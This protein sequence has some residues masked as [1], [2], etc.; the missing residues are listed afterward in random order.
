MPTRSTAYAEPRLVRGLR[1]DPQPRRRSSATLVRPTCI[2]HRGRTCVLVHRHLRRPHQRQRPCLHVHRLRR[3]TAGTSSRMARSRRSCWAR[4]RPTRSRRIRSPTAAAATTRRPTCWRSRPRPSAPAPSLY[5]DYDATPNLNLFVQGLAGQSMIDQPDHGGR[6]AGGVGHRHAHH[7]L[8]GER[9]PAGGRAP[10]HGEREPDLLPDE[11]GRRPRGPGP[12]EPREAGQQHL[13]RHR[14][15]QVGHHPDGLLQRLAGRRL[16]ASTAPPT[17]RATSRASCWIASSAAI[18]AMVDPTNP[19][20][21][22]CRAATI[23]PT[24]WGDCVPLNLFGQGNASD[25][26]IAYVDAL[27]AGPA[28]SPRR[29]SS[30]RTA[31]P[32]ARPSPTPAACG[33]VYN[34]HDQADGGRAVRQRQG[35]GWLGRPHRRGLRRGLPQGRD[36]PDRLRPEQS[37]QRSEHL[38]GAGGSGAAR[39]SPVHRHA[40]FDGPELHRGRTSTATTT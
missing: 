26:A 12:R 24:K 40:Q 17:T 29:C 28:R 5:L 27:H 34:T 7:D 2:L 8:P 13:F 19:G 4:A 31:M 38:S 36:R 18:D 15:L 22:V 23:N 33:K 16:R 14:G 32:A 25:A 30:S 11:R 10:D 1:P 20:N 21:I 37:G 3:C 35:L 39:R 6:F 9:L